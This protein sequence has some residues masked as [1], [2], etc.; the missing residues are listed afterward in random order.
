MKCSGWQFN[1]K[2]N[3]ID[4]FDNKLTKKSLSE[5]IKMEIIPKK[6]KISRNT[7]KYSLDRRVNALPFC[8]CFW[9]GTFDLTLN[10][11]WAILSSNC[12]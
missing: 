3:K 9:F 5:W 2:F 6:S 7:E 4:F 11:P 1:N 8:F 12:N 10:F